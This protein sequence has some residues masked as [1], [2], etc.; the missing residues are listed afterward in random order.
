[1]I[2]HLEDGLCDFEDQGDDIG[3]L[4]ALLTL[5]VLAWRPLMRVEITSLLLSAIVEEHQKALLRAK[6][7][8]FLLHLLLVVVTFSSSFV[9]SIV[10]LLRF[11]LLV[12]E[13]LPAL[14]ACAT[15]YITGVVN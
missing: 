8:R 13:L 11:G 3:L 15:M 1:M 2:H 10:A 9:R 4:V 5:L 12:L 6:I 7:S 14:D